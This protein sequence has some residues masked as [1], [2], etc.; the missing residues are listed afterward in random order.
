MTVEEVLTLSGQRYLQIYRDGTGLASDAK[1][2]FVSRLGMV[3]EFPANY[4]LQQYVNWVHTYGPLWV[5]TDAAS[6]G[7]IFSPHARILT[8]IAGTGMADGSGTNFTF[9][10]PASGQETTEPFT[11]F[12][13]AFEQM[14]TENKTNTLFLQIVHF[15]DDYRRKTEGFDVEGPLNIHEPIHESLTLAALVNSTLGI[16]A[17]IMIGTD[18]AN[19]EFLRG[20]FWNDDP[21]IL[22]FNENITNNWDFHTI[23]GGKAWLDQFNA[24][25][26]QLQTICEI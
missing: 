20:V 10:D 24:G 3:T 1:E 8:R 18:Q 15:T 25:K 14:V 6:T 19:N 17:T 26:K 11:Q 4:S 12:L 22:F 7:G 21:A 23:G 9:I 13:N 16:P 2:D 5:T